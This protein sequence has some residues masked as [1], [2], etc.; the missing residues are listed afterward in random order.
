MRVG[1]FGGT[2]DPVHTGHLDVAAAAADALALER[3]LVIPAN[4]P[5]HRATPFASGPHRFAMCALAVAGR[6][7]L[8]LLDIEMLS[9]EPAFTARTLDRLNA[10][11]MQAD[12]MFLITGADAFRDIG[13]WKDYPALLER[14]HFVVVSRPGSPASALRRELPDLSGRMI[15]PHELAARGRGPHVILVEA[16]TAPVSSTEIRRRLSAGES[17]DGLVPDLVA[18]HIRT[19]HLYG[20][21]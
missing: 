6:D 5:P 7:R 20:Q 12:D 17:I 4:V 13:S 21:S 3:V 1:L 16:P 18:Q 2:F 11:G 15:M 14:C 19:H 10:S 9:N 8:A